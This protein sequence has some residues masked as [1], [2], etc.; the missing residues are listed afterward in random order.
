MI[1]DVISPTKEVYGQCYGSLNSAA[2]P[3]IDEILIA[4]RWR[5]HDMLGVWSGA[6]GVA[7]GLP[8]PIV[9]SEKVLQYKRAHYRARKRRTR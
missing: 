9:L 4:D 2:I 7:Q 8:L 6:I 3:T 5:I 1:R